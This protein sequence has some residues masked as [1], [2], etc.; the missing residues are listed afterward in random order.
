MKR[1]V[2]CDKDTFLL[3]KAAIIIVTIVLHFLPHNVSAHIFLV[4]RLDNYYVFL[5][6]STVSGDILD[7][8]RFFEY[9]CNILSF[10]N[11]NITLT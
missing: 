11:P 7:I 5:Q 10:I 2:S 9:R 3:Y 1:M 8:T 4:L 6:S